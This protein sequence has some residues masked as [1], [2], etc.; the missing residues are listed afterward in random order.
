MVDMLRELAK[1]P[2]IP[3]SAPFI[4]SI[5]KRCQIHIKT[6]SKPYHFRSRPIFL[7]AKPDGRFF[8]VRANGDGKKGEG[9][10][11]KVISVRAAALC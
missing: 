9:R 8:H 2:I 10:R 5:P 7:S 4:K 11:V 1:R 6:I 3:D